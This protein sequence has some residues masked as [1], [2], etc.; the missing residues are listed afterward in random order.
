VSERW[1]AE[2]QPATY[3]EIVTECYFQTSGFL[4][5]WDQ[6]DGSYVT[7][8]K[9]SG[10][11]LQITLFCLDPSSHLERALRRSRSVVFFSATMTPAVYFRDILGC[12][13]T[14]AM[15]AIPSPFP[16]N[17]LKVFIAGGISTYYAQ[18]QGSVDRVVAMVRRFIHAKKGN[19]LCFFPS[20]E[21]MT[22]VVDRFE[23]PAGD[24]QILVQVR[25]MDDD[26]RARFL[27]RFSA[28]N[29]QT[30]VGFAVM[31]GI[32]GE[33]IDLVGERLSG[34][35]IVGVGLPAIGPER[36][37]IR[38]YFDNRGAGFDFAYR[39]PGINRVL[40]A[41]GRVIRTDRDRGALLLVD[42]RFCR[43]TYLRLLP[44]HWATTM[45]GSERQLENR[46]KRF[47]SSG[48]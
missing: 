9:A 10:K 42:Q 13:E 48:D 41:A 19:Y 1:L 17:N 8:R 28:Q 11:D 3:R 39:F 47:W 27:D 43:S 31:G 20:Y 15:L 46:L 29:D 34:A 37:L 30:L 45:A 12:D 5:V 21:Y 23:E 32:F 25:E 7:C 38:S 33:G 22:M 6:F 26:D 44:E 16:R 40:Q 36:D 2:N 35:V 14:A 18:R 4:R 24:V